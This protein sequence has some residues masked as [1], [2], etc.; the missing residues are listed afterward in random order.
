MSEPKQL[1]SEQIKNWRNVLCG[2]IGPWALMMPDKEVQQLRDK[3]Q[4]NIEALPDKEEK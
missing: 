2:M 1:T 4:S 3:M